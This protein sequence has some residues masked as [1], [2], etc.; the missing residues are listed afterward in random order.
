MAGRKRIHVVAALIEHDGHVLLDLR[1]ESGEHG[2]L[3][4]FPGG[5]REPGESDPDALARELLEELGVE[6]VVDGPA[7]AQVEHAGA[8][9][10]LTLVLY[11]VRIRGEPRALEVEA[12]QWFTL[13]ALETLPMPPADR[14]LVKAVRARRS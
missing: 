6:A 7:I 1:R 8:E 14:P 10:D 4:E 2:G 12:V 11:P 3:W 5:K 13:D 9:V